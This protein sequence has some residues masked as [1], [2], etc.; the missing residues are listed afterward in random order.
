MSHILPAPYWVLKQLHLGKSKPE[1]HLNFRCVHNL[2]PFTNPETNKIEHQTEILLDETLQLQQFKNTWYSRLCNQLLTI[3]ASP[4]KPG[5]IYFTVNP[6]LRGS[7]KKKKDAFAGYVAYYLD[8]DANSKYTE[9]QRWAQITY[10]IH[11]G[12]APSFVIKSGHGFH[13]YWVLNRLMDRERGEYVL[14]RMV[15]LSGCKE[16]GNTFDVTRVLRLP[17]FKNVKEWY[18]NDT[19]ECFIVYPQNWQEINE[20]P[21]WTPERFETF[22]PSELTD[23]EKYWQEAHR[24]GNGNPELLNENLTRI[25]QAAGEAARN[26]ELEN[27]G[28]RIHAANTAQA[29][30]ALATDVPPGEPFNPTLTRVPPTEDIHWP[31]GNAW[32]RKYCKQGYAKLT[33]EEIDKLKMR[34]SM[35]DTSASQFDFYI[36]H[37]L[38]RMG[39]TRDAIREFWM[40]SDNSLYRADKEEKSPEY[41]DKTFDAALEFVRS[42]IE[43][44]EATKDKQISEIVVKNF[45]TVL[46]SEEKSEVLLTGE[47]RLN[48]IYIDKDGADPAD[49]EW[50]DAHILCADVLAE[51]GVT[52][53]NEFMPNKVFSSV[54]DLKK[55]SHDLFR[56]VTNNNAYIQRVAHWL[57]STY[58]NVPKH[59]FHSKI[60]YKKGKY[61]FPSYAIEPTEFKKQE[62]IPMI[63]AL[64]RK[65]PLCSY[66]NVKFL[67]KETILAQLRTHWGNVLKMHLP[68]VVSSV[69]GM[70]TATAL[71][72]RFAQDLGVSTWHIPTLNV[73]GTSHTAK[74]ETI[75][76]LCTIIGIERSKNVISTDTTNFALS[77]IIDSTNC[78][79]IVIDEF[80]ETEKNASNIDAIRRIVRRIYSGESNLRGHANQTVTAMN[81][82]TGLIVSGESALE[83]IGDVSEVTRVIPVETDEYR[84]AAPENLAR[85]A[86]LDTVTWTELGPY[87]YQFCLNLDIQTAHAEYLALRAE[88]LGML[89]SSFGD[90]KLRISHN[91][92]VLWFGCRIF[93]RF[94]KSMD[95]TLPTIEETCNPRESLIKYTCDYAAEYGQ[96]LKITTATAEGVTTTVQANNE[97]FSMLATFGTIIQ[98]KYKIVMDRIVAGAFVF[99][100]DEVTGSLFININIMIDIV[101][102]YNTIYRKGPSIFLN[103]IRS[104]ISANEKTDTSVLLSKSKIHRVG[105]TTVRTYVF[106]MKKLRDMGVWPDEDMM[107]EVMTEKNLFTQQPR[108]NQ[109]EIND[110]NNPL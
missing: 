50:Y 67:P 15:K 9:D 7:G 13:V 58:R 11:M 1:H 77:K 56:V 88:V 76:Y 100:Q 29:D 18:S 48:S 74:T 45:Q 28:P 64:A 78:F 89:H 85:Y 4:T 57:L 25:I 14:R 16:G 104:I 68:R 43:H 59:A 75:A 38:V 63:E 93:D 95:P 62:S 24:L 60:M 41:F 35:K 105:K 72:P 107:R 6:L 97:L 110:N 12:F 91:L 46:Q 81:L 109:P 96:S 86:I 103:K 32:M 19:P 90:E 70:L 17:G 22:P 31:R 40:R 71:Q 80:K 79:P 49:R 33:A 39:Y 83:R 10:W 102:Q 23:L 53:I 47:M 2:K 44:A 21:Q 55:Y 87:F 65:F 8:L 54:T 34:F 98:Q 82:H 5:N 20:V 108:T 92:T 37:A 42:A 30:A 3:N 69:I 27:A 61:L 101:N 26:A 51:N 73:R 66:F 52:I 99:D 36:V 84:P 106:A 94:I